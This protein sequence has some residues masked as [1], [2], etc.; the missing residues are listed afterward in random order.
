MGKS[1]DK[2]LSLYCFHATSDIVSI[3]YV[4]VC[5]LKEIN[6]LFLVTNDFTVTY[7]SQLCDNGTLFCDYNTNVVE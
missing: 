5:E 2:K 4:H 7:C 1:L 6:L 3:M